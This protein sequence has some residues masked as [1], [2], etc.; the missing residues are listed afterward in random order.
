MHDNRLSKN[1]LYGELIDDERKQDG[2]FKRHKGTLHEK[3]KCTGAQNTYAAAIDRTVWRDTII[4][5]Q[6]V[7]RRENAPREFL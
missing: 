5:H 2:Q 3:P 4:K 6:G 7:S 1:I